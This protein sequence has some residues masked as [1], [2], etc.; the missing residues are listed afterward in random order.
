[1][2]SRS[3]HARQLFELACQLDL[4]GI[5]AKRADSPYEFNEASPHWI[6][7]ENPAC[8]QKEGRADLKRAGEI[9][10]G[11]FGGCSIG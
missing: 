6:K 1:L 9:G 11:E 3:A 4:E 2:P 10:K 5:V 7:I 8:S